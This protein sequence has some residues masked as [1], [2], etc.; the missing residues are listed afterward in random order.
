MDK[1]KQDVAFFVSFCVE[2]YKVAKHISGKEALSVFL[3]YGL[4]DY[5]SHNFEVLHTQSRQWLLEE[6]DE[7]ISKR[8]ESG[9]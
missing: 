3:D 5:L 8:K 7:Y 1:Q 6:I 4:V 2:E 9:R